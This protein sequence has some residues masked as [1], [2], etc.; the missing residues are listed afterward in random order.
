MR[1]FLTTF[2]AVIVAQVVLVCAVVFAALVVGAMVVNQADRKVTIPASGRLVQ[3]IPFELLEFSPQPQLPWPHKI[4]THTTVL[5]NLEKACV[6]S[7]VTSVILKIDALELGWGKMQE[8]RAR[9]HQLRA[10][11]KPVFAYFQAPVATTKTMY[12]A[13]AC[14]SIFLQPQSQV[15]LAGLMAERYYFKDLLDQVGIET[16]VSRIKEYKAA[17]EMVERTSMS[18]EA[19][20]NAEWVL[21][22]LYEEFLAVMSSDRGVSRD[23]AQEWVGLCQFDA[24]EALAQGL[25]DGVLTWEELE[26]RLKGDAAEFASVEGSDYAKVPRARLG[27]RGRTIAVIHGQGMIISGKA[28]WVYPFGAAMGDETMVEALQEVMEDDQIE[29]ILLRLDTPGGMGLASER[30]GRMVAKA[31]AVKPLVISS[32]DL[33]A[34]GGYMASYRCSTIVALPNSIVGSIGSFA[35]RPSMAKLMDKLGISSDRVTV[36]P[37]A[38]FFST[39]TPLTPEEF[40]RFDQQHWA[41]YNEWVEGV[42]R[43]R[44][45]TLAEVDQL[46]RGRVFT[47]RQA[48][49]NGL[50]DELGGYDE[51]LAL[52]KQQAG[53]PET[54]AVTVLHYP[55]PKSFW[56]ELASGEWSAAAARVACALGLKSKVSDRLAESVGFWATWLA[57]GEPLS[58]CPWRI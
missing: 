42:A 28:D 56:E 37:H 58:L 32:V 6:D 1:G 7:R 9:V 52:V 25:I 10:A 23:R 8:I 36:G 26:D 11:G 47:G 21:Q 17:A 31:A 22:D 34:S 49:Q 41:G 19:R 27:L 35:I 5:E 18:P 54:A 40:A 16:Q 20:A 51:A 29:G 12:L 2:L 13:A 14:D 48:L 57:S 33:N 53:I 15:M 39:V 43:C 55:I 44:G 38:T 3:E 24:R 45:K 30:I 4:T 50:I 46:A